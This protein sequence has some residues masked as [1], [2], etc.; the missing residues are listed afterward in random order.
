MEREHEQHPVNLAYDYEIGRFPVTV[1]QFAEYAEKSGHRPED[2]EALRGPANAPV[3]WVSWHEALGFCRWLTTAWRVEK[4]LQEGR[5]VRLP[6]EAEWEK[7][8]RGEDG[9]AYPWGSGFDANLGNSGATGIGSPSAVG[10]FPGGASPYGAEELSGSVWEWTRSIFA[11]DYG[12][13][14]I[15]YPYVARDGR[16]DLESSALRVLRGGAFSGEPRYVRCAVRLRND[17]VERRDLIG[18]RV[19]VSPFPL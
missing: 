17:P 7:A 12:E 6:S 18:F 11:A 5:E 13:P 16:E 9:R 19:V 4:K 15:K 3:N 8:A 14:E 2:E 10:C 1:A